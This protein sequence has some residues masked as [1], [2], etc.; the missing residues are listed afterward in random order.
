MG[1]ERPAVR[2][3]PIGTPPPST[4]V[5]LAVPRGYSVIVAQEPVE[6]ATVIHLSV[7]PSQ[8]VIIYGTEPEPV[9]HQKD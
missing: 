5:V 8:T 3:L 2:L 4:T 9:Q 1:Q 7:D 6:D